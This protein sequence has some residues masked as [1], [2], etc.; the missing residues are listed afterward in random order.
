MVLL[1]EPST[2][3]ASDTG[4]IIIQKSA[5][6]VESPLQFRT[7]RH[8]TTGTIYLCGDHRAPCHTESVRSLGR[9]FVLS[10]M[11]TVATVLF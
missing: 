9:Q 6:P 10:S 11:V 3:H 1:A 5:S 2:L 7:G 4:L 8:F